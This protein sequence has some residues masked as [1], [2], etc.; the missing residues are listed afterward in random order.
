MK[1][2]QE[3]VVLIKALCTCMLVFCMCICVCAHICM[4]VANDSNYG[5]TMISRI[6]LASNCDNNIDDD[7]YDYCNNISDTSYH[8]TSPFHCCFCHSSVWFHGIMLKLH[9]CNFMF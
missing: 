6:C 1:V 8:M 7:Y 5:L 2:A 3:K 9:T 4:H